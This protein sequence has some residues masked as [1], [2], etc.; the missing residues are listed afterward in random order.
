MKKKKIKNPNAI[1]ATCKLLQVNSLHYLV[2][3]VSRAQ[4]SVNTVYCLFFQIALF[5]PNRLFRSLKFF[6]IVKPS[7]KLQSLY[8]QNPKYTTFYYLYLLSNIKLLLNGT[9]NQ[10]KVMKNVTPLPITSWV[11]SSWVSRQAASGAYQHKLLPQQNPQ[12]FSTP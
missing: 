10:H 4:N 7:S 11:T 3:N 8:L 5:F 6:N 12:V 9:E 2:L 1:S